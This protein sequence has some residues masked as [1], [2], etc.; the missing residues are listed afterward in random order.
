MKPAAE[1][2][3][4]AYGLK[5]LD[6]AG[7]LRV[8]VEAPESVAA[9]SWGMA[10]AALLLCPPGL[11]RGR[12][13]AIAILHDLPEVKVGDITPHDGI[14]TEEKHRRERV[15]AARL[16]AGRPELWA[17][18]EDY[19]QARSPEARFVRA[20]DK[21]DMGLQAQL[22]GAQGYSTEEFLRSAQGR[23]PPD[24]QALLEPPTLSGPGPGAGS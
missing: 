11:D 16:F 10:L 21:L 12:V 24:L 7:W 6:R 18:W 2:L 17:L 20:L 19:E 14:S 13:L 15:A 23:L 4:E 1:L 8:G 3:R 5:E 22:Y 9:H